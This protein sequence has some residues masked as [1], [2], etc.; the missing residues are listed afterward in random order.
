MAL[1]LSEKIWHKLQNGQLAPKSLIFKMAE[2][3]HDAI[4]HMWGQNSN[5]YNLYIIK[6]E[7]LSG[8]I[9]SKELGSKMDIIW[10]IDK[11]PKLHS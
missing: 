1:W 10:T 4:F 3:N 7:I 9:F 2:N 11:K 8:L 5:A 6:N